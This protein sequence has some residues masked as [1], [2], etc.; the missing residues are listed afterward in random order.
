MTVNF[1]TPQYMKLEQIAGQAIL[2]QAVWSKITDPA[3][4]TD[5]TPV[6]T[7]PYVLGSFTPEGF[8][9]IRNTELLADR[10]GARRSTSRSTPRTPAR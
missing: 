6:G 3:T 5:P 8:T 2:P 10:P 1:P 9:M 7:G 4:F